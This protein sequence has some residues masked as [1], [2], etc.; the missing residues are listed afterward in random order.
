ML[1]Y[2]GKAAA[3]AE[4][5]LRSWRLAT[6]AL[7][8]V[9]TGLGGLLLHEKS[10]RLAQEMALAVR[11]GTIEP[12]PSIPYPMVNASA[13]KIEPPG[14]TSYFVLT[15]RLTRGVQEP[16]SPDFELEP[17]PHPPGNRPSG[18]SPQPVP[19]QS[20]DVQRVLEL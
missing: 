1:Y 4:S 9:S 16:S 19:L 12:S 18:T 14:P 3:Q 2:A 11:T 20:W 10:Q 5:R 13:T 6:A 15:A 17:N 7:L 8:L